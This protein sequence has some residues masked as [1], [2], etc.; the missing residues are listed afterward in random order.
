VAG[1]R[2]D[3]SIDRKASDGQRHTLSLKFDPPNLVTSTPSP[4]LVDDAGGGW[5]GQVSTLES[6]AGSAAA[7]LHISLQSDDRWQPTFDP[8]AA[9]VSIRSPPSFTVRAPDSAIQRGDPVAFTVVRQGGLGALRVPFTVT[10]G[11]R[12]V[13]RGDSVFEETGAQQSI[14]FTDYD[15]CGEPLTFELIGVN[16]QA[17]ATA[18]FSRDSPASCATPPTPRPPV[19]EKWA[20]Q[21]WPW[22][23][24]GL[25]AVFG[26]L[27]SRAFRPPPHIEKSLSPAELLTHFSVSFGETDY[28]AGEP[29]LRLPEIQ[30]SFDL[31]M[32]DSTCPDPLPLR[33]TADV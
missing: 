32:G 22:W 2:I 33:E 30:R 19:W 1:E 7:T 6:P 31:S 24:I 12:V 10:Q 20:R 5:K 15:R 21:W 3:V 14:G 13:A 18:A 23:G 9:D 17:R 26:W 25:L 8:P 11:D 29:R 4:I 28:P 16:G 27:A